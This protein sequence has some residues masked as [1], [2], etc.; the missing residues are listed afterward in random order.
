[1]SLS[2][3]LEILLAS[4]WKS[5]C[6][7]DASSV[8]GKNFGGLLLHTRGNF[9]RNKIYIVTCTVNFV[10]SRTFIF[11]YGYFHARGSSL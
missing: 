3:H 5:V 1:M 2:L 7:K 6:V 9:L 8:Q 10:I 4:P 11:L